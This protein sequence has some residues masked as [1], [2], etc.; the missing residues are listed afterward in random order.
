[1][2]KQ[3]RLHPSQIFGI[4][5]SPEM[6]RNA[7]ELHGGSDSSDKEGKGPTWQAVDFVQD[8]MPPQGVT[9]FAAVLFCAS[10]H[11]NSGRTC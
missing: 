3:E 5:L 9:H 2:T 8:F 4:D 1:L 7:I 11:Q 10:L 6:I